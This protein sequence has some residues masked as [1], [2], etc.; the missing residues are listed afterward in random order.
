MRTMK[1]KKLTRGKFKT[2]NFLAFDSHIDNY[3][4]NMVMS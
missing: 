1:A 2:H 3:L 4:I